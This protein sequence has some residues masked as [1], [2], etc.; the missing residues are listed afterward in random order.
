MVFGRRRKPIPNKRDRRVRLVVCMLEDIGWQLRRRHRKVN[1][2]TERPIRL[3]GLNSCFEVVHH[4]E[5]RCIGR[6]SSEI[7]RH[8]QCN[9]CH[10]PL[11]GLLVRAVKPDPPEAINDHLHATCDRASLSSQYRLLRFGEVVA[12]LRG[13]LLRVVHGTVAAMLDGGDSAANTSINGSLNRS[14]ELDA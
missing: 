2:V 7:L 9:R 8:R 12:N 14:T 10:R 5:H 3:R 4:C 1:H 6:V 11:D 13:Q